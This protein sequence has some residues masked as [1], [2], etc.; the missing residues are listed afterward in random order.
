MRMLA[1]VA[2]AAVIASTGCEKAARN[3]YDQPRYK[4][5]AAS[6]LW[7]DGTSARVPPAGTIARSAGVL[8]DTSSGALGVLAADGGSAAPP[9]RAL[10]DRG[11]QRFD[12]YC[13]PCH[14]AGGD[15]DGI[16]VR[17]GFPRPPTFHDD[18]LRA[19]DDAHFIGVMTN[20][21][22]AMIGMADR[23]A[24]DDRRAIVAWVRALQLSRHA[25]ASDVPATARAALDGAGR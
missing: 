23:I 11:H 22:G 1:A 5:F 2:C 14:G 12:I 16:I 24:P 6:P 18:K 10:Y 15:G 3:M 19:A 9:S 4:T 25:T 21:Y 7:A 20:G 17:R 13:A 8:A